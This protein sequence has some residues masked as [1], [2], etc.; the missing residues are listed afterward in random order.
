VHYHYLQF[1]RFTQRFLN[2]L[3]HM[4]ITV[5]FFVFEY[6]WRRFRILQADGRWTSCIIV[7][8]PEPISGAVSAFPLARVQEHPLSVFG[9]GAVKEGG[10]Y[11]SSSFNYLGTLPSS[12]VGT[13]SLILV[14]NTLSWSIP[15]SL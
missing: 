6:Q 7:P 13:Y 11:L 2:G 12:N 5:Y 1:A 4:S 8:V 9:T 3:I 15:F 14:P 10:P